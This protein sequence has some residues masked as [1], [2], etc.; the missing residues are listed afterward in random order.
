MFVLFTFP[1]HRFLPKYDIRMQLLLF[2]IKMLRDRI[3]RDVTDV[4]LVVKSQTYRRWLSPGA[5]TRSPKPAG[6]P[7]LWAG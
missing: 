1:A 5:K 7:G 4:M 6:C 3:D 2:Q